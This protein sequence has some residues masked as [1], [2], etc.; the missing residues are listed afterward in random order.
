MLSFISNH[1]STAVRVA[2]APNAYAEI[3]TLL[4][5]LGDGMFVRSVTGGGRVAEAA[6][7][8]M[9]AADRIVD[10]WIKPSGG[11]D[12]LMTRLARETDDDLVDLLLSVVCAAGKGARHNG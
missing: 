4:A 3:V 9:F 8:E 6:I 7:Y 1:N 12:A 5:V 11:L 2:Y 10:R